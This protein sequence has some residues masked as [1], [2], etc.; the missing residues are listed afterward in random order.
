MWLSFRSATTPRAAEVATA[1][2]NG[3]VVKG[4]LMKPPPVPTKPEKKPI[5]VPAPINPEGLGFDRLGAGFLSKNIWVAEKLT[6]N[7][8]NRAKD[9]PFSRA[10][11]PKL[12]MAAP[13]TIPRA[14]PP[15]RFQRMAPWLWCARTLDMDVKTMVA[16]DVAMAILLDRSAATPWPERMAVTKRY[17]DHASANP[18]KPCEESTCQPQEAQDQNQG[19]FKVHGFTEKGVCRVTRPAS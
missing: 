19:G 14:K 3:Y 18:R 8:K 13:K 17:H 15:T 11:M 16:I 6:N 7:A 10:K 5:T 4:T 9:D 1:H 12:A 2:T